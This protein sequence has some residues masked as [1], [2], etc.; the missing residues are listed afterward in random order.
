VAQAPRLVR[1]WHRRRRS[2][3]PPW[4]GPDLIYPIP[5]HPETPT[6]LL[7]PHR[8]NWW[9][10]PSSSFQT[11]EDGR[12]VTNSGN[13][14]TGSG[15]MWLAMAVVAKA[16][17][18][19]PDGLAGHVFF[20]SSS[21]AALAHA[22]LKLRTLGTPIDDL[23]FRFHPWSFMRT[24]PPSPRKIRKIQ[25]S[26]VVIKW[27]SIFY[28]VIERYI[29]PEVDKLKPR[30]TVLIVG[31]DQ[32]E[33]DI[34]RTPLGVEATHLIEMTESFSRLAPGLITA[35]ALKDPYGWFGNHKRQQFEVTPI[36]PDSMSIVHHPVDPPDPN[37][38]QEI[39]LHDPQW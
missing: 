18:S 32:M 4:L 16:L 24:P 3:L 5:E 1:E 17:R 36:G 9:C 6:A 10:G 34:S 22:I 25:P 27:D 33:V 12:V 37:R 14:V 13:V 26:L 29:L 39:P 21:D 19:I 31:G 8:N 7:Y 11:D 20:W 2:E 30:P 35:T 38:N 28:R 15:K 23:R